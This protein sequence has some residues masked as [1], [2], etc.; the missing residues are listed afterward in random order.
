MM[1]LMGSSDGKQVGVLSVA[2]KSD[3]LVN[4]YI[5]HKKI[6]HA[7]Q[8]NANADI[9]QI[10]EIIFSAEIHQ[11]DGGRGKNEEKPVV[12]FKRPFIAVVVMVAVE[13]P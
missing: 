2:Q 4:K 3:A 5:V 11:C 8:G 9:E 7:I 6:G 10:I 13:H 1:L 12:F